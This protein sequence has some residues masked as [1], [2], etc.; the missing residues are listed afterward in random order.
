MAR[1]KTRDSKIRKMILTGL[2]DSQIAGALHIK[3]S[4]VAELRGNVPIAG[5]PIAGTISKEVEKNVQSSKTTKIKKEAGKAGGSRDPS[6][7]KNIGSMPPDPDDAPKGQGEPEGPAGD[8]KSTGIKFIGGNQHMKK[9]T[10]KS[11]AEDEFEYEC[12]NCGHEFNEILE[13]C[14]KC[15]YNLSAEASE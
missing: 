13:K 4:V 15:G 10:G 11:G 5:N 14:P 1:K 2:T 9:K 8:P 7:N 12:G 6:Q 3:K